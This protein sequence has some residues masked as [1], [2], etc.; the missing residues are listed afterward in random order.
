MKTKEVIKIL[1]ENK[2][3]NI[4]R[5]EIKIINTKTFHCDGSEDDYDKHPRVH[6]TFNN[7]VDSTDKTD[8]GYVVC[9]YCYQK[10]K[11]EDN[12]DLVNNILKGS[13]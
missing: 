7:K 10:F 12:T 8:K 5:K 13:G 9:E 2:L 4:Q 11:Y 1:E 6:Y 3:T